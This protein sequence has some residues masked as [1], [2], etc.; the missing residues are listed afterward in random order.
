MKKIVIFSGTTEGHMLSD[1]LSRSG[2]EHHV[3]V[4]SD[5]GSDVM[6][7]N[8]LASIH[9]GRMDALQMKDYLN[10]LDIRETDIVIDATHPYATEVTHNIK[11]AVKNIGAMYVR[12]QR[13]SIDCDES[14]NRYDSVAECAKALDATEGNILLTIGSNQLGAYCE[15][16]SDE[17]KKRTY[18][19]ILPVN[20]SLKICGEQDIPSKNIIAMHGPFGRELNTALMKQYDIKHIVTKDSGVSGGFEEK[21][22]ASALV[23]ARC[24]VIN[25]P[26]DDEGISIYKAFE[27]AT[28]KKYDDDKKMSIVIAG[29]G[30]GSNGCV[31]ADLNGMIRESDAVFGAKRLIE[32]VD[33]KRKYPVYMPDDILDILKKDNGIKKAVILYTGDCSFYSGASKM[34]QALSERLPD[35][36]IRVL[37]GI[38]SVSYLSAAVKESYDDAILFSIHGRND[39]FR[40]NE[41]IDHIIY[42][43]K[44]FVLLSG[45]EDLRNV[46]GIAEDHNLDCRFIVGKDLSYDD[47]KIL[48]LNTKEAKAYD[49]GGILTL[50]VINENAKKRPV[51]GLLCDDMFIR[52]KVPMTKECIRNESIIRLNILCGD[53][54]YDIGGGTGSVA[55]SIGALH[56]SLKVYTFEKKKEAYELIKKNIDNLHTKN[57]IP[58]LGEAPQILK[59]YPVPDRVFIGG[60]SKRLKDIICELKMRK[61]G[62]R[63]VVNAVSLETMAA[64][65][66][67]IRDFDAKDVDII[68]ISCSNIK[69]IGEHNMMQSENPV[70]IF[71][72][73]I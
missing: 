64:T 35:A 24:H 30:P 65:Q 3:C 31:I 51:T 48:T 20:E 33:A 67:I 61:T 17:T 62:I 9:V 16:V 45:D 57:V 70:M 43:K 63:Y 19:R 71:A 60:S 42:N 66:D 44:T 73:T 54:V 53:T 26:Q 2:V 14:I 5:Y 13:D 38:S 41:L 52:D 29:Y 18:V 6:D 36:N 37:P 47:E 56:P 15:N 4:A 25:R 32:N 1:M 22:E 68:Q 40:L 49:G 11:E 69:K 50:L 39:A 10:G 34:L 27:M 23:K 72:F 28:G 59:D 7:N 21:L 58:V 8:S 46:A 55:I 12:I